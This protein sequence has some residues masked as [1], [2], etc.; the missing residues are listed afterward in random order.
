MIQFGSASYEVTDQAGVAV[1][2][3]VRL[4]GTSGTITVH[5][6]TVAVNATPGR[7]LHPDFGDADP[8]ARPV[9]G[10]DPGPG[11]RRS[12]QEPRQFVNVTLSDPT[13]GAFL[14]P[15][16]AALLQIQDVD[17]DRDPAAGQRPDL[18][19]LLPAPSRA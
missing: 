14:G 1:I 17:P 12:L 2:P 6:Q 7:R 15:T 3:V 19:G 5:Y 13:G 8:R 10:L 18:V 16:T 4:Y 11:A 9:V